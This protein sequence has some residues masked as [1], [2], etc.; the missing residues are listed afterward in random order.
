M[1]FFRTFYRAN[2]KNSVNSEHF[3]G[4]GLPNHFTK[5]IKPIINDIFLCFFKE[6]KDVLLLFTTWLLLLSKF[7]QAMFNFRV[8]K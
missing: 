6:D 8:P 2:S 4:G 7:K 3:G 1:D 5:L